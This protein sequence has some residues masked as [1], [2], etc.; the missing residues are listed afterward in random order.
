M[1][2]GKRCVRLGLS[3]NVSIIASHCMPPSP[4]DFLTGS[5]LS[6]QPEKEKTRQSSLYFSLLKDEGGNEIRT[7]EI[8]FFVFLS[9]WASEENDT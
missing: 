7:R 1:C 8:L 5:D 3:C 6:L 2:M 9:F 4:D